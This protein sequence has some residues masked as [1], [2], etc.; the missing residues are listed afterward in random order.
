MSRELTGNG[1]SANG[2][3]GGNGAIRLITIDPDNNKVYTE[4]YFTEFDDY[5]DGF[6]GKEELDRE[7]LTGK[8]RGHQEEFDVDLSKPD[9]WSFAKAGDDKFVSATDGE[10]ATVKLDASGTIVPAGTEVTYTWK[11]ADGNV[12]AS[13]KTADVEFD[14]GTRILTL[15]V[16]DGTGI[17]SS[18]QV[19]VTVTGNRTLLSGNFND[20][21]AMGWVVP[22][23]KTVSLGSAGDFGLPAMAGDTMDTSD[24]LS[25]PHFTKDQYIQLDPQTA[26]PTGDGL[27]WSYSIVMDM[28]IPNSASWTSIFQTQLNNTNDAELYLENV[29]G[30][31]RFGVDGSYHGA[32]KYGEWQRVAFTIERQ[33]TSNDVVLKKYIEGQFVGSQ[34]IKDAYRFTIDSEKGFALFSDDGSDTS[35][36]F[37]SSIL[38]SN[39][40]LTADQITS[41]GRADVDGISAT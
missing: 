2:N 36:G 4:T 21:N 29:N 8:F 32:F 37:V 20:G 38:F 25:F 13:G 23:Q 22:G 16:A 3:N 6:R 27:I 12:V 18:D 5:L 15:E 35:E 31:G 39:K 10:S 14:A 24:V 7:G 19:R 1:N 41:F 11:D 28:L 40:V 17:V 30:T 26:S 9:A 34:T 33:G